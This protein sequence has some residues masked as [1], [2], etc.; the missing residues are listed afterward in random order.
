MPTLPNMGLIL[1][2]EGGDADIWD[3]LLAS[4]FELLDDHDHTSGKGVP[5]KAA[6]LRIDADVPFSY[7]SDY[8]AATDVKAVDFEPVLAAEVTGY[9]AALWVSSVD[10]ELYWRTTGGSNVKITDGTELNVSAFTGG[11]GGDYA[12]VSALFSFDDGTDSYWARQQEVVGVRAWARLRVG[13]LDIYETAAS[14]SNRVRIQSPAALAASYALTLPAALPGSTQ[15]AQVSATGE[16]SLSNTIAESVVLAAGKTITLSA[17]GRVITGDRRFTCLVHANQCI[18]AGTV[19]SET[20]TPG[21]TQNASVTAYYPIT[22]PFAWNEDGGTVKLVS[23]YVR[24]DDGSAN[25]TTY[26]VVR[27]AGFE[28]A[29]F[30]ANIAGTLTTTT[31]DSV[32]LTLTTPDNIDG[33]IFWVKVITD[34]GSSRRILTLTPTYRFT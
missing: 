24:T 22:V 5:V 12:A 10:N 21:A 28:D 26:S 34:A 19:A 13:D 3:T 16:M 23:V 11:I 8:F 29:D 14:I 31:A 30:T 7:D 2:T 15:L 6:G 25:N 18:T 20:G 4:V 17:A 27:Q 32:L 1:P 33:L 9:A